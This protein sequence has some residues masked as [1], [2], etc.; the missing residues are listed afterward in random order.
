M[1]EQI[2]HQLSSLKTILHFKERETH[3][4]VQG[5]MKALFLVCQWHKAITLSCQAKQVGPI[6]Q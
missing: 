6:Q 3:R 5:Q 1:V 2:L 4:Y